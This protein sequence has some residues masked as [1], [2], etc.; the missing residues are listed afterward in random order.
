MRVTLPS[1]RP[2]VSL[3]LEFSARPGHVVELATHYGFDETHTVREVFCLPL[4]TGTDLQTMVHQ[5]CI[6]ISM[7]LQHGATMD[8]LARV[9]GED[10]E[11]KPRSI[12]G[13]I[14]R[15]GATLDMERTAEIHEFPKPA[16]EVATVDGLAS[17]E[18]MGGSR[19]T[20]QAADA[21]AGPRAPAD[22]AHANVSEGVTAGRVPAP[23]PFE[24]EAEPDAEDESEFSD[25]DLS[26]I[27]AAV[28]D[29]VPLPLIP[30]DDGVLEIP[31]FLRRQPERSWP[32][33]RGIVE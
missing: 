10:G 1:R 20:C 14:V 26:K 16:T 23:N 12:I 7:A 21:E 28:R 3:D 30:A 19:G 15:V 11:E 33:M 22:S 32:D 17:R 31:D 27:E 13:H 8:E 5:A 4:K 6:V 9:L 24:D 18:P 29:A 2:G 25:V